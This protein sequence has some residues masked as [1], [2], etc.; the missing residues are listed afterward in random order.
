MPLEE[1]KD[2]QL[3]G[4]YIKPETTEVNGVLMTKI[5]SD[6]WDNIWNF[7]AKSDDLLIAS[8]A[9]SGRFGKLTVGKL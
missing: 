4:K 1:M 9:K 5:I 8:Y 6:N 3:V 2:L 7:Q